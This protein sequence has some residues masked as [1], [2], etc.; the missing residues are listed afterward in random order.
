MCLTLAS[1]LFIPPLGCGKSGGD[2]S[3]SDPVP[4]DTGAVLLEP[5]PDK[6]LDTARVATLN[7]SVGFPVAQLIFKNMDDD[8]VAY[9]ELSRLDSLFMLGNPGERIE[10]MADSCAASG[11]RVFGVQEVMA[12]WRNDE[13]ISDFLAQFRARLAQVTGRPW[14]SA[15]Q[16]LNDSTLTGRLGDDS[17][18]IHFREGNALV[19]DAAWD[20][21]GYRDSV[22]ENLLPIPIPGAKPTERGVQ[23]L[24]L[25]HPQGHR[26]QVF[27]THL[28]VTARE[29]PNQAAEMARWLDAW[30]EPGVTQVLLGDLNA[31]PDDTAYRLL[32][33]DWFWHDAMAGASGDTTTC[34][35]DG[36]ELW[37]PEAGFSGRR[38]DHIFA[39]RIWG[40][41]ERGVLL[42]GTFTNGS[43]NP[44]FASDHRLVVASL[45]LQ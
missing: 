18:Q 44:Q 40:V 10:A 28:E 32:V 43:G 5:D 39:K 24:T 25:E 15:V 33:T 37:N 22:F 2:I 3:G 12:Y 1:A 27:N 38:I 30:R 26:L 45:L 9:I 13:P 31:I 4:Q 34:C 23:F 36:S 21:V 8:S 7:F 16:V 6:P 11:A 41:G 29:R 14:K 19:W 17:L 35:L 42:R 20:S